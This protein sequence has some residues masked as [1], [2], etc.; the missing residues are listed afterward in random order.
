MISCMF[1][2]VG[3]VSP[4]Y[5]RPTTLSS[6][7]TTTGQNSAMMTSS[8]SSLSSHRSDRARRWKSMEKHETGKHPNRWLPKLAGVTT[9]QIST[10]LQNCITICLSDFAPLECPHMRSCLPNVHSASFLRSSNSL[11]P[12]PLRRFWRQKTSFYARM[13]LLGVP[14]I[15]CYILTLFRPQKNEKC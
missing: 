5:F 6:T 15:N 4:M 1:Q 14:K 8:L 10:P 2:C 13:C 9:F 3:A 12:R 11:P 7:S